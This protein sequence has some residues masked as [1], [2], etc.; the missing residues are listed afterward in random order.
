MKYLLLVSCCYCM[1]ARAQD[2]QQIINAEKSFA[3]YAKDVDTRSAFLAFMDTGAVMFVSGKPQNAIAAWA[4]TPPSTDK[5]L[6]SPAFAGISISDDLGFPTGPWQYKKTLADTATAAGVF[7]SVW[8][9]N[10][11]GQ[12]KNIVDLGYAFVKPA[13]LEP[14]IK[15]SPS[16]PSSKPVRKVNIIELDQQLIRRYNAQGGIAFENVLAEDCW[17]N[18]NGAEPCTTPQQHFKA[19]PLI[20]GGLTMTPSGSGLSMS[21][22]LAYVYGVVDNKK[23]KENYLRVWKQTTEGW[24]IILQVLQWK[25]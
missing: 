5:L 22:D 1:N 11:K 18:I 16:L 10:A 19:L 7:T 4:Q 2:A 8:R 21:G 20:P 15:I 12:W 6:W 17:S 23:G 3:A 9:K 25:P 14:E 24:K 13:Y